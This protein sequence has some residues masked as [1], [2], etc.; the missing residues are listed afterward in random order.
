MI[1][2]LQKAEAILQR[3]TSRIVIILE[4]TINEHNHYAVLRTAEC[5]GVQHVWFVLHPTLLAQE[6]GSTGDASAALQINRKI[7]KQKE[8]FL[9]I[10]SFKTTA[11][12]I[13]ASKREGMQLWATDL[14]LEAVNLDD[15]DQL[16]ALGA[17]FP[18]R[19]GLVIGSESTGISQE[20][21]AAAVSHTRSGSYNKAKKPKK[22][23]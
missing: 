5:F 14:S 6:G 11:E 13:A 18:A 3:R 16:T 7:T 19:V 22:Y 15:R 1:L 9:T 12:C 10:R 17:S 8:D 4:K 20:M 2:C 23:K 21:L